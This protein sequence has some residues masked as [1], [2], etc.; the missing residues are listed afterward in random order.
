M[1]ELVQNCPKV[2]Q[3]TEFQKIFKPEIELRAKFTFDDIKKIG[4][5]RF[6]Y[7]YM[8]NAHRNN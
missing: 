2:R 7:K 8:N 3:N 6:C 1:L 5:P 4:E